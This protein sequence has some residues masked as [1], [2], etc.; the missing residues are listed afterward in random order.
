MNNI[1][2]ERL[3]G[4]IKPRTKV[5]R[6]FQNRQ[7]AQM[8]LDG[9]AYH[10]NHFRPHESPRDNTPAEVAKIE[11]GFRDWEG[12]ARKENIS[13]S[14]ARDKTLKSRTFTA[15]RRILKARVFRGRRGV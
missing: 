11:S 7:A 5:M 9:W 14:F 6:G 1:L 2:A 8:V 3:Q 4:T 12:V 15:G 13:S 10:Y